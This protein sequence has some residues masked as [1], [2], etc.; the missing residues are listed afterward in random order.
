MSEFYT[1]DEI[2]EHLNTLTEIGTLSYNS[3][4]IEWLDRYTDLARTGYQDVSFNHNGTSYVLRVIANQV[5]ESLQYSIYDTEGNTLQIYG[6]L[7]EY[8]VNLA[9]SADLLGLKLYFYENKLYQG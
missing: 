8:P 1:R 4:S 2:V 9:I 5:M 6:N 3:T 7:V